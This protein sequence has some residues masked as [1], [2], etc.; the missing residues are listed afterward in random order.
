MRGDGRYVA[1]I[2]PAGVLAAKFVRAHE[3]HAVVTGVDIEAAAAAEGVKAVFIG[4]DF[5]D[6]EIRCVSSYAAFQESAQPILALD[7]V[8]HVGEALAMVVA[9]NEYLAEDASELVFADL[10]P[11]PAAVD[12]DTALDESCAPLHPGWRDNAF[13]RRQA[14]TYGFNDASSSAP[15]RVSIELHN[16]RH[17]GIPLETRACVAEHD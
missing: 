10:E 3:A 11:L 14:K 5:A 1:D 7:R 13:V 16:A 12:I 9:D 2:N 4:E 6:N 8:R 15:H 17:S